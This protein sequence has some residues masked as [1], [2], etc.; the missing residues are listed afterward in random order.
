MAAE[1]HATVVTIAHQ[2]VQILARLS[3]PGIAA[4]L[5]KDPAASRAISLAGREAMRAL[6][7]LGNS[8]DGAS[9]SPAS[10]ANLR[11]WFLEK[12]G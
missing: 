8:P 10:L 4:W 9:S 2:R 7:L 11:G 5:R 3:R 1:P 12:T 6:L